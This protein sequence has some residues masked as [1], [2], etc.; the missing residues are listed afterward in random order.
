M[1]KAYVCDR[2]GRMQPTPMKD[3]WTVNPFV[4]SNDERFEMNLCADCYEEFKR[5]L[6]KNL[7]EDGGF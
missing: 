6:M 4:V 5:T 2:C 7:I 1:S 3:L